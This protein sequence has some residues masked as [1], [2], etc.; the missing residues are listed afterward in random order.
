MPTRDQHLKQASDNQD[1]ADR[2]LQ[3]GDVVSITWAATA[4][5]YS[6]VHYGRAF[7]A[8]NTI[9]AT[10]HVGFESHFTR[11]W[12]PRPKVFDHYQALKEASEYARYDC[13][14]YNSS[15]AERLRD[16]H[17]HPFRDAMLAAL[18]IP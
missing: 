11:V 12:S 4:L 17:F 10:S 2:L 9:T 1:F 5:F 13:I 3:T 18:G 15:Q 6:A 16:Q 14:T 8:A 7:L